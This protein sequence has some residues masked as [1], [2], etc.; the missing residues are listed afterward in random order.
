MESEHRGF[1]TN[2]QHLNNKHDR[3]IDNMNATISNKN[4][5]IME[6]NCRHEMKLC[7]RAESILDEKKRRRWAEQRRSDIKAE[8]TERISVVQAR[9]KEA[10]VELNVSITLLTVF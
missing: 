6:L 3:V 10:G 4:S 2:I 5:E 1:E 8:C 7:D 9:V